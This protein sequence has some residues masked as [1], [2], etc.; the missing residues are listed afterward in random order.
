MRITFTA[1]GAENLST[2]AISAVLKQAGHKINLAFDPS[3]FND[4]NYFT[5]PFLHKVFDDRKGLINKI[6][7]QEP[8]IL[9]I[10]VFTDNFKWAVSVAED[11]KQILDIPV[12]FGGIYPTAVPEY[13]ISQECVDIVCVGEGEYPMLE[14]VNSLTNGS[15]DYSIE[16]LWFKR[17]GELIKNSPRPLI[18]IEELPILDKELFENEV[19]IDRMYMTMTT[20]GCPYHCSYCSQN[21]MNK[22]NNRVEG[23]PKEKEYAYRDYRR[24]S[25]SNVMNE[26]ITMKNKYNYREVGFYDSVLVVNKKWT[27]DL[28]GRY[29]EEIN[30]PFRAI[31]H[32]LTI[33]E[34]VAIALKE[35]G[36]FRVQLGIQSF[37]E[38]TRKEILLRPEKNK[39][40]MRCFDI[41]DDVDVSYSC[42]HM[43]GLPGESEKEQI[44]AA[45]A[46]SQLKNRVRITCFWTA[47]FPKTDLVD[48]AKTL[49]LIDDEK[50]KNINEAHESAYIAGQHGSVS[51]E[52][53]IKQ[54]KI[55]EILFRAMPILPGSFVNY[56]LDHNLQKLIRFLPKK[57]TLFVVDF[58]VMI[59]KKDL[60]G[61]QYMFF[62]F[63]HMRRRFKLMV[64]LNR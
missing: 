56:L 63:K 6:I 28:L 59:V 40:I 24:R 16:N 32:P 30:V 26:L 41:L 11:V 36:C 34:E 47:F 49:D 45:R 23:R 42:D 19:E 31:A 8:D 51:R 27:L 38:T 53:M 21:F 29:K 7:S 54:F 43:F 9:A 1:M 10:S 22:F 46:Y 35:A 52:G 12:I 13:V 64:G 60:S 2:E 3:L 14:L 25:V 62:Y 33:N 50:I 37:N 5:K 61:F 18:D 57:I 58:I 44:M 39:S 4:A 55:Y 20:K 17:N 48:K 15:I